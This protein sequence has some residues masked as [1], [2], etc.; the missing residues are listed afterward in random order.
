MDVSPRS[1][2]AHQRVCEND[3]YLC[4]HEEM[5]I[6]SNV[7]QS[8]RLIDKSKG[9]AK[10]ELHTEALIVSTCLG[11]SAVKVKEK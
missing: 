5:K 7:V 6:C 9:I 2:E 4:I 10:K 1:D 11:E 3:Y 8:Q